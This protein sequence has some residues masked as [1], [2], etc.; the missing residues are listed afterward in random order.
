MIPHALVTLSS[1]FSIDVAQYLAR[2]SMHAY[3]PPASAT[4]S[5][6]KMGASKVIPLFVGNHQAYAVIFGNFIVFTIRGTDSDFNDILTD[7]NF[8]QQ[9][10]LDD[11][12]ARCHSG[13]LIAAKQLS[14]FIHDVI[15]DNL[16]GHDAVLFAGHSMGGAV[17]QLS[18][19]LLDTKFKLKK[20]VYSFGAPRLGNK[21]LGQMLQKNGSSYRIVNGIDIVPH[22]PF[23]P[24]GFTH[25][26][27]HCYVSSNGKIIL[28]PRLKH[29]LLDQ[30]LDLLRGVAKGFS[31][32][33]PRRL[34]HR[35]RIS[36][37]VS[38]LSGGR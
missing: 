36:D 27:T 8:G 21:K 11:Q 22:L 12:F 35:H 13:F 18:C 20:S 24:M 2:L 23:K 17:A 6:K 26:G 7:L 1:G 31:G 38:R 33:I 28:N 19:H 29:V 32:G 5:F 9:D 14:P 10:F 15:K 25:S 4:V 30:A 16:G 37:Y 3:L 34:F